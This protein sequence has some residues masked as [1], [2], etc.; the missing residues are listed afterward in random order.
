MSE[1]ISKLF[2]ILS[3]ETVSKT[4]SVLCIKRLQ[5]DLSIIKHEP[6]ENVDVYVDEENILIWYFLVCNLDDPYKYGY[7]IG[8][9]IV[10]SEYPMKPPLSYKFFT[11]S[12]RFSVGEKIC[13]SNSSYHLDTWSPL[14]NMKTIILGLVSIFLDG[15][16]FGIGHISTH[17][18]LKR[19]LAIQSF[20]YNRKHY[21]QLVK[22]FDR[23]IN[24]DGTPKTPVPIDLTMISDL[25]T[26][27]E[28]RD[29]VDDDIDG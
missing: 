5:S 23:F 9:V 18:E 29:I 12:G 16:E 10:D 17:V 11:P 20:E 22:K 19:S 3:Y 6:M 25:D 24:E 4:H 26:V 27:I 1:D 13:V 15:K 28:K 21:L 7:Y 2:P 14:W 8:R